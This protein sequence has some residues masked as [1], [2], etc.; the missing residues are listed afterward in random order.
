MRVL[1]QDLARAGGDRALAGRDR[2]AR[3]LLAELGIIRVALPGLVPMRDAG[4]ALDIHADID[5][6]TYRPPARGHPL[7]R[8]TAPR[9][10]Q[11]RAAAGNLGLCESGVR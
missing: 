10:I 2:L 4:R 5:L 6:H 9:L 1:D 7:V 11:D 3:H 8:T